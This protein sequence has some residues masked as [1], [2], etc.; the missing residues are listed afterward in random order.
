M[1]DLTV[2]PDLNEFI[3]RKFRE[4]YYRNIETIT[5]PPQIES[6][7]IGYLTFSNAMV[8]H[9]SVRD[10]GE[11]RSLILRVIPRGIFA[12]V[13]Y[14][15]HPALPIQ[16]KGF[17][18]ADLFLDIDADMLDLPCKAKHDLAFC[19]ACDAIQAASEVT[20]C[21]SCGSTNLK[22]QKW[23][24]GN[25]VQQAKIEVAK[26]LKIM[27]EELGFDAQDI[28]VYFSGS[29]GF[30]I[31]VTSTAVQD[32]G[33]QERL[34]LLDYFLGRGINATALGFRDNMNQKELSSL[35][36]RLRLDG[37]WR[38]KLFA[39]LSEQLVLES[40]KR[41][42]LN[43]LTA[44]LQAS[45]ERHKVRLDPVVTGDLHRLARL[46][47]SLHEDTGLI[48]IRCKDLMKFDPFTEAVAFEDDP[49]VKVKVKFVPILYWKGQEYRLA[50]DTVVRLP[51]GLAIYLLCKGAAS[52]VIEQ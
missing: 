22:T 32:L 48:K 47:G 51:Q 31:L 8:R 36:Q 52:L 21:S 27:Q 50:R 11:L 24:C 49:Q 30:H 18:G 9:L 17:L 26:A 44:L 15:S 5:G 7:E 1:L 2:E 14:Y 28:S 35:V 3:Y 29:R 19:L 12:S 10:V 23:T 41:G 42:G 45:V 6:R 20:Q 34:E 4:Y 46:E 43:E 25:C 40:Y 38:T 37:G 13:A 33:Q 39:D 16:D